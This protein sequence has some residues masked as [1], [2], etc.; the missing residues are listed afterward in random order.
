[1]KLII[2]L[3]CIT[4]IGLSLSSTATARASKETKEL[5]GECI[6]DLTND[7]PPMFCWKKNNERIIPT[8]C[9]DGY[10]RYGALCYEKCIKKYTFHLG[11]CYEN[12]QKNEKD[13]TLFC[14]SSAKPIRIKKTYIPKSLTNF[15][16]NVKCPANL[17]KS[18]ALC[19][20]DCER[21]SMFN[22]GGEACS[23]SKG[24]CA[25]EI[26]KMTTKTIGKIVKALSFFLKGVQVKTLIKKISKNIGSKLIFSGLNNLVK[27]FLFNYKE[28]IQE[29]I[30]SFSKIISKKTPFVNDSIKPKICGIVYNAIND[31]LFSQ[32]T[33]NPDVENLP[34]FIKA[35]SFLDVD[36]AYINCKTTNKVE[37][38]KSVFDVIDTIDLTGLLTFPSIFLYQR[39]EMPPRVISKTLQLLHKS[40]STGCATFY[41]E[42]G[43]KGRQVK[44]FCDIPQVVL[45]ADSDENL[46]ES[47]NSISV[48][49]KFLFFS[50][51]N[52]QGDSIFIDSQSKIANTNDIAL[53]D[54]KVEYTYKHFM[55][56]AMRIKDECVY[57]FYKDY[58][59]KK[60]CIELCDDTELN[61]DL[62]FFSDISFQVFS[63]KIIMYSIYTDKN[64]L[65][66]TNRSYNVVKEGI[67][68]IVK[69]AIYSKLNEQFVLCKHQAGTKEYIRLNTKEKN[70]ECLSI[71][72][73]KCLTEKLSDHQCKQLINSHQKEIFYIPCPKKT[74]LF[75]SF[76]Y[77]WCKNG[78]NYSRWKN[79][80]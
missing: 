16:K 76:K 41:S 2:L 60:Q 21:I 23:T 80:L 52:F 53:S 56:S 10:F 31:T 43:N 79:Y 42:I 63:S 57:M 64:E 13:H 44:K 12:C 39:C 19:Y 62:R 34:S 26:I 58:Y 7:L 27:E 72:G 3:I 15:N 36:K 28:K 47:T 20:S 11:L 9:P 71:D 70:V 54:G 51:I 61:Y 5:I 29:K 66:S 30:L 65:I 8:N 49:D 17:I 46:I 22:C 75:S 73:K 48:T 55:K 68:K 50:D 35:L 32:P 40:Q 38:A 67:N 37:C 74:S 59:N 69:I 24:T 6:T 78:K 33:I 14:S 77:K 25:F 18:G 45:A 4:S 1:M